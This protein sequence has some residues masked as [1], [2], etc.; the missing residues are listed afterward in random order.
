L[1]TKWGD[2]KGKKKRKGGG[3]GRRP[4]R[5]HDVCPKELQN[6]GR[7]KKEGLT[8]TSTNRVGNEMGTSV[9]NAC[10]IGVKR[11]EEGG[12]RKGKNTGSR[13]AHYKNPCFSWLAPWQGQKKKQKKGKI[14]GA[15][16][17]GG[18]RPGG[19]KCR[20]GGRKDQYS[21]R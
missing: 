2:D 17:W 18:A 8:A 21:P 20:S 1:L 15:V 12:E 5:Q 7:K 6:R 3:G 10:H 13:T 9:L 16:K 14:P 4:K 19:E 11:Y